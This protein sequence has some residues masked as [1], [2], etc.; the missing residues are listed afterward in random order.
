MF[1]WWCK[2]SRCCWSL[3]LG[4]GCVLWAV[5]DALTQVREG[6]RHV[7]RNTSKSCAGPW[8]LFF[9]FPPLPRL[10]VLCFYILLK[11]LY[12][13]VYA[14]LVFCVMMVFFDAI[15]LVR[16]IVL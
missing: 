2:V 3:G 6:G 10:Q 9:L 14:N 7:E 8:S 13:V 4:A 1:S 15:L 16:R 5:A 11:F 12:P